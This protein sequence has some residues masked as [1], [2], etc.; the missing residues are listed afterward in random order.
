VGF[1]GNDYG[2]I[3]RNSLIIGIKSALLENN[4]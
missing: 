4:P 1:N 3:G 2:I